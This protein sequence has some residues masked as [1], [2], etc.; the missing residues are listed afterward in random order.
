[1]EILKLIRN[2]LYANVIVPYRYYKYGRQLN[3][4]N[5]QETLDYI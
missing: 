1:M 5:S 4:M 2:Y 3:I